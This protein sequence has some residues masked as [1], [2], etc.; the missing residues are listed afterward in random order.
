MNYTVI[1]SYFPDCAVLE[2]QKGQALHLP[3]MRSIIFWYDRD[4]AMRLFA[5]TLRDYIR[6]IA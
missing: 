5:S 4:L 1:P 3:S 2:N 6:V